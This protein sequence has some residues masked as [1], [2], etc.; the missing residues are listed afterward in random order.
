MCLLLSALEICISLIS[1]YLAFIPGF[2]NSQ[3]MQNASRDFQKSTIFEQ[4][5][6]IFVE[7]TCKAVRDKNAIHLF[8]CLPHTVACFAI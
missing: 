3:N 4:I 6:Q 8:L 7:A 1:A 5:T 2:E